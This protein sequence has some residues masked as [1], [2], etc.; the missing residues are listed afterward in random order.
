ME[1]IKYLYVFYLG[2]LTLPAT[3]AVQASH[4]RGHGFVGGPCLRLII[5]TPI[6]FATTAFKVIGG[7]FNLG[8]VLILETNFLAFQHIVPFF[9][10]QFTVCFIGDVSR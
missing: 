9:R 2:S 6:L 5:R 3:T 8:E 10:K 4:E 1:R 7:R